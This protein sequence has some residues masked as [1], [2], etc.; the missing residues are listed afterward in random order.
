MGLDELRARLDA[1]DD[2]ILTLLSERALVIVQVA[3]FKRQH[4]MPTHI[5][6]REAAIIERLCMANPG[7]LKG[8]AIERISRT[9]I[10]EMRKFE[11]ERAT[12]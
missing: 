12:S 5:P 9:I 8:E 10:E 7:P 4:N 1:L 11:E 3:E 2:Q 6:H